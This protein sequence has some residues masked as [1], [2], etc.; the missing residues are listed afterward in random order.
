[1]STSRTTAIVLAGDRGP[2]DPLVKAAGVPCK[3]LIPIE[4]RLMVL[5]VV[6]ALINAGIDD[7]LLCGPRPEVVAATDELRTLV[8]SG[9]VR[10]MDFEPSPCRSATAALD[11]VAGDGPILLTTADHALLTSEIVG[12]FMEDGLDGDGDLGFGVA[13][14][15]DVIAA[16]PT[17]RRTAHRLRGDAWCGCNLFLFRTPKARAAAEYWRRVE[18]LRKRPWKAA[19]MI[20]W[21]FLARYATRRLS[22]EDAAR[23]ISERMG[24]VAY[25]VRIHNPKAAVDVD[26]VRDWTFVKELL[27]VAG[28]A[29][30]SS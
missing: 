27:E 4:G 20:G 29:P 30:S 3:A 25:P 24:L 15:G 26:S 12:A 17:M 11:A 13:R 6:D 16:F 10:W 1:M 22:L 14:H 9:A 19:Q 23:S 7:V 8:E 28:N 2:D 21:G 5:R 18:A